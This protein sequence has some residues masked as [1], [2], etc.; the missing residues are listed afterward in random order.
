MECFVK[1][2]GEGFS[3]IMCGIITWN[4]VALTSEPEAYIKKPYD[5]YIYNVS[6]I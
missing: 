4:K 1:G 3:G 5:N 2:K 6:Y